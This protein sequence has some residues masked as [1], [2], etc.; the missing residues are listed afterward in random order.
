MKSLAVS[1][2]ALAVASATLV[3]SHTGLADAP[4][5]KSIAWRLI[6]PDNIQNVR[7]ALDGG[8][9]PNHPL[10][11]AL[12][13]HGLLDDLAP[14]GGAGPGGA[15]RDAVRPYATRTTGSMAADAIVN[16]R[17]GSCTQC[18]NLPTA[19]VEPSVAVFG[20]QVV[21]AFNNYGG[22][23]IS[24]TREDY[25]YSID[26]G[27]TYTDALGFPPTEQNGQMYGDPAVAVNRKTGEFY[28]SALHG[29]GGATF[30]GV[31]CAKGHFSG[32]SFVI[33]RITRT[34]TNP[35][36]S[37][38]FYDRPFMTV[39]S[40][41]GNVYFTWAD[42]GQINNAI[43]VQAFD[44]SLNPI[45]PP[46][47]LAPE[48]TALGYQDAQP[49]VGPNGEV[50]VTWWETNLFHDDIAIARSADFGHSFGPKQIVSHFHSDQWNGAPGQLRGFGLVVPGIA[51]DNTNGPH[52]GRAYLTWEGSIDYFAGPFN[53]LPP[54]LDMEP[55]QSLIQAQSFTPG[56]LLRGTCFANDLDFWKFSGQ[57]GQTF[58][59]LV[60]WDSTSTTLSV[61]I[62]HP[63]NPADLSTDRI[64]AWSGLTD[65][66]IVYSLPSDGVYYA[67]IRPDANFSGNG[68]YVIATALMSP[69]PNDIA[70]DCSRGRTTA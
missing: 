35:D 25:A 5:H 53:T 56:Q 14:E 65:N 58:A 31:G 2:R 13:S 38:H 7:V 34:V 39:D 37:H 63:S 66:G 15:D 19:Q 47:T 43:K 62:H 41:T 33:D 50:Y 59:A 22:T 60:N 68:L 16:L 3:F 26:G 55:N 45:A 40:L 49:A 1:L 51:V 54:L 30:T 69:G 52:R 70:L 28:I 9:D 10:V 57:A 12:R 42:F 4:P 48:D 21:V 44:A 46:V 67:E 18:K 23:C 24:K 36:P 32:A 29:G 27:L 17:M 11:E 61:Y 6:P 8:F 64:V 20:N